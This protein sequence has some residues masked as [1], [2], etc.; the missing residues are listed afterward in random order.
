MF[1]S[2]AESINSLL[3]DLS[4]EKA[5]GNIEDKLDRKQL[6][7]KIREQIT[8]YENEILPGL[9][10]AEQFD[11]TGVN[12]YIKDHLFDKI[13]AC[14]NLP[15]R[16]QRDCARRNLIETIYSEAGVNTIAQKKAV[17]SYLQ[18]FL[19]IVEAHYLEKIEDK[20]WFL[21]GKTV[22]EA[23][24]LAEKY[25]KEVENK[26]VDAVRYHGSFAEYID[27]IKQESD[28]INAFHYRNELLKFRGREAELKMLSEF[29][30]SDEELSWIAITGPGGAGKSKLLYYFQLHEYQELRN[31]GL[32]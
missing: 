32:S 12:R 14:F 2:L 4:L 27:G 6:S 22:E 7:D 30:E 8:R 9:D 19:Q 15:E 1:E 11:F 29:I 5:T 3:C 31:K 23:T 16:Y 18:M 10:G 28:N 13:T 24:A 26:I 21:A 20:M 17:Y 25:I